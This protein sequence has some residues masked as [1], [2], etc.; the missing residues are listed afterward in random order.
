MDR[1][2]LA[3]ANRRRKPPAR[4]EE[5]FPRRREQNRQ[6]QRAYRDRKDAH[7]RQLEGQVAVW[8]QKHEK[9]VRSY[10]KQTEEVSRLKAQLE[11]LHAQ[12]A[13]LQPGAPEPWAGVDLLQPDLDIAPF[14]DKNLG[15]GSRG[16]FDL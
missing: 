9:L 16:P 6:S 12:V 1:R 8:K 11:D 10:A 7:Q 5:L 15:A 14:Y 4:A 13:T 3:Q 2:R